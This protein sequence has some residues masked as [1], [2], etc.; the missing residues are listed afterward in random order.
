MS[1][2]KRLMIERDL[3]CSGIV[4]F[5]CLRGPRYRYEDP[6]MSGGQGR[7]GRSAKT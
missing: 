3:K 7:V 4:T 1:S 6:S 2:I 5:D